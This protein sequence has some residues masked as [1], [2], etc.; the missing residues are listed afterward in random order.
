MVEARRRVD[1]FDANIPA[2][3][4]IA[5]RVQTSDPLGHAQNNTAP[6]E[7]LT[8]TA[9]LRPNALT[10]GQTF[11]SDTNVSVSVTGTIPGG[12]MVIVDD[13]NTYWHDGDLTCDRRPGCGGRSV[14]VYVRCP[15]HPARGLSCRQWSH[16]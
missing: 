11:T 2:E 3:G 13:H 1:Q 5:Y 9:D 16:P 12:F 10:V 4:V 7:L 6:I 8:T 15:R 14:G